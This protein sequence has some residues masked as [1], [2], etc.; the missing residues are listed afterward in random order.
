MIEI[1]PHEYEARQTKLRQAM[2]DDG[3]DAVLAYST[4][5]VQANVRWLT[6]YFI[7]FVGYQNV[8]ARMYTMFGSC[9]CL[10]PLEGESVI[11]SDQDWDLGRLR[12]MS[13]VPDA[14]VSLQLGH[15]LGAIIRDRGLKRV[16][17]DN[18]FVFPAQ[19]YLGLRESAPDTEFV[20]STLISEVRRVKSPVEIELLRRAE[21]IADAAVQVGMDAVRVGATE[22]EVALVA[23]GK[24]R[25]LGDLETAGS[26]IIGAGVNTATGVPMPT[27]DKVIEAGEWVL[28]DVLPRY[29]GYCGD[30]ARMRLAGDIEDLDPKLKHLFDVTLQMNREVVAAI[31]PGVSPKALNDLATE[32]A[33]SEGVAEHKSPLLGHATGLDIHDIPDYYGDPTP[34]QSGEVITI[35]PCLGVPGVAGTRVEDVVLVTESGHEVL[36]KTPRG[37][38]P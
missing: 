23:E 30:I 10:V 9:A 2:E 11:R 13:H 1:T 5:K 31:K 6:S 33:T 19:Y 32:I 17:I 24:L 3:F 16:A 7:R 18:W 36:S 21:E 38:T 27:R 28:F 26:S 29:Q 8:E 20:P 14:D 25:E 4:A 22:Y 37:L 34:L 12:E 35:E 15:D